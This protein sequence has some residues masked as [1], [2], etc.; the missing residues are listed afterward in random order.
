[1]QEEH[2][3]SLDKSSLSLLRIV[4]LTLLCA[5][6]ILPLFIKNNAV[7]AQTGPGKSA[8]T[9]SNEITGTVSYCASSTPK[10]VGGAA[11]TAVG[12][13]PTGN[14]NTNTSGVYDMMNMGV[15]FYAV[16]GTKTTQ[17]N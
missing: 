14:A 6:F 9:V 3:R 11:M 17:I 15:G 1:M 7:T 12:G 2:M 8:P 10:F 4:L 16:S 5:L 13:T